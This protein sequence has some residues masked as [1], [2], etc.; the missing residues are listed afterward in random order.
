[1]NL[2]CAFCKNQLREVDKDRYYQCDLCVEYDGYSRFTI[3]VDNEKIH[4]IAFTTDN[5]IYVYN[6]YITKS[7]MIEPYE[8]DDYL[9]IGLV[10]F[11]YTSEDSLKKQIEFILSFS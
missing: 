4:A 5:C 9:R 3:S 11:D 1:M 7:T 6:N 10:D 2:I 8:A